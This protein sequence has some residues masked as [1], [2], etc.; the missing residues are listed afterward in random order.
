[1]ESEWLREH[2][3]RLHCI[4]VEQCRLWSEAA[5]AFTFTGLTFSAAHLNSF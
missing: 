1:M 5:Y 3:E 4:A 2:G